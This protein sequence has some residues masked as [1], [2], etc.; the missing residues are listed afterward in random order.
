MLEE[1]IVKD[2]G[3]NTSQKEGIKEK[4]QVFLDIFN[5]L[6]LK[7]K[8]IP[9]EGNVRQG[10]IGNTDVVLLQGE[11]KDLII[12][13]IRTKN[14]FRGQGSAANA[15]D[16]IIESTEKRNIILKAKILPQELNK[17]LGFNELRIFYEKRG[18]VFNEHNEGIRVPNN[19]L[20]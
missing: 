9:I 11:H 19:L 17:G 15:L 18:F 4:D 1:Y 13:S 3:I 10:M 8:D 5:E 6:G 16:K 2:N 12:E 7:N 14:K 20:N